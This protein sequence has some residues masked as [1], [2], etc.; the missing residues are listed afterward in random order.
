[1]VRTIGRALA[2]TESRRTRRRGARTGYVE[3]RMLG[4]ISMARAGYHQMNRSE[5]VVD[6]QPDAARECRARALGMGR[7]VELGAW[8]RGKF[9]MG[10]W[11]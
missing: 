4:G 5:S 7:C 1:M 9:Q 11:T 6:I 3:M 8:R 10:I 2:M